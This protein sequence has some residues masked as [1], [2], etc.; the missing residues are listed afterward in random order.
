MAGAGTA[1]AECFSAGARAVLAVEAEVLAVLAEA[2]RAEEE[3][4]GGGNYVQKTKII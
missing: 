3:L 2:A 4:A 1:A